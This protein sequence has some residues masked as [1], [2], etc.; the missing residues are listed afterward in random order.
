MIFVYPKLPAKRTFFFF[1]LA[2][3]GLA[4]CLFVYARAICLANRIG[5]S[6][7]TPT[8]FNLSIGPYLRHQ[9]DKR[10]YL[11]LFNGGSEIRGIRK[12]LLLSTC[13]RVDEKDASKANDNDI[14]VVSG[15]EGFFRPILNESEL[16]YNYVQNHVLPSLTEAVN[17]F[18]F[19]NCVAVHIRLG[20]YTIERRIPLSWYVERIQ[21]Y[22]QNHPA[23]RF[24][25]FS[26]G[27]KDELDEVLRLPSVERAFFGN[28][29]ADILAI[30]KCNYLIGSDSTF[31]AW[32]AYLGQ[33]P[34]RFYRLKASPILKDNSN[35]KIELVG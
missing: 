1:R 31:S 5:A 10:H 11:G 26:D 24:L 23:A 6:I 15:F 12:L 18:D 35:E 34:C 20:D 17:K 19:A 30:S 32:G 22:K 28:A 7:I 29:M 2:G 9:A 33:V 14:I 13:T 21:Q 3:N 8:W 27:S 25:V 4:N 16:V